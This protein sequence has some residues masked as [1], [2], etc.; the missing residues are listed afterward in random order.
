MDPVVSTSSGQTRGVAVSHGYAYLGIPYAAPPVGPGRYAAPERPQPWD[1]VRLADTLSSTPTQLPYPEPFSGLLPNPTIP[2]DDYLTVNVWTP[3]PSRDAQL[4]VMVWIPGG[5]FVRGSNAIDVYDGT[6]FARD[7]VVLVSVNYRLGAPGFA[8]LPDAPHNRGLRDQIQA[9]EW[10]R[11][12]IAA[13]G[14]DPEQV[15]I[16]GESA[17]GMSVMTLV[18]SPAARGLFRRAV[19]QSGSGRVAGEQ[20]DLALPTANFAERLGVSATAAELGA[21]GP[22]ATVAAQ[23]QTIDAM[24]GGADPAVWGATTVTRGGGLMPF[25]PVLDEEIVPQIPE[26]ALAAGVGRD[27][28]LLI[29]TTADEFRFF[30]VPPGLAAMITPEVLAG[31]AAKQGW[32]DE[33][34]QTYTANRPGA[35]AGDVYCA[36]VTDSYFTAPSRRAAEKHTGRTYAYEFA[37]PSE[38]LDLRSAHALEI[39]FVFDTLDQPGA[40]MLTGGVR[41]PQDLADSMHR[42]WVAFA[43]DG[44]PGWAPYESADRAVQV[45]NHP[46]SGTGHDPR[47]DELALWVQRRK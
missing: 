42:S 41:G 27:I 44:D 31:M 17:G 25:F 1:G 36:M 26:D 29:G 34:V 9:L 32:S 35:T 40:S 39:G 8:V 13:F 14:G 37:W 43:Q 6:N 16:F 10:V 30:V 33:L 28:D 5:A 23:F 19:V 21:I 4:P 45:F 2:G 15:T 7:G 3:D 18:T 46:S 47:A 22:E 38:H 11:D 24:R 12:N 20:R